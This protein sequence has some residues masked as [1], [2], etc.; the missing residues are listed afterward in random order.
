MI[1]ILQILQQK[2]STQ[3]AVAF[4]SIAIV[5]TRFVID[6][7]R[8]KLFIFREFHPGMLIT[9]LSTFRAQSER[10]KKL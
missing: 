8:A 1:V 6:S 3:V 4:L 10:V 7:W 5:I 2:Y 9:T